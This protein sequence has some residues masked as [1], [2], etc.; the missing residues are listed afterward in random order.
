MSDSIPSNEYNRLKRKLLIRNFI[1][2]PVVISL[3][4][5]LYTSLSQGELVDLNKLLDLIIFALITVSIMWFL[6]NTDQQIKK[7]KQREFKK[8]SKSKR[9]NNKTPFISY[10]NYLVL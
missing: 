10:F 4:I 6:M 5:Y 1:S 2:I 3:S 9:H 7:E 8:K